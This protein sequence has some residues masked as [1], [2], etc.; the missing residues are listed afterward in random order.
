MPKPFDTW[1]VLPHRPLEKLE[2]NLWYVSG[3]MGSVQRMMAV[4][5]LTDGRLVI[6]NAVALDEPEMKEL[7]AWGTPAF[8]VVPNAYHRV[9]AKIGKDRYPNLVVIAPQG[10][11]KRIEQLLPV[12]R[13]DGDFGDPTV[14][15]MMPDCIG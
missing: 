3:R 2:E 6:F 1:T 5:R 10:G 7:E 9:D 8:L 13:T 11:K 14:R 12:D 4:A 15:L